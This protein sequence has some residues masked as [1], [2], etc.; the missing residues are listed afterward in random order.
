MDLENLNAG[1]NTAIIFTVF[2]GD[3]KEELVKELRTNI[4]FLFGRNDAKA[5]SCNDKNLEV[6]RK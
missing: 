4:V 5:L 1:M 2:Y 6:T 3:L